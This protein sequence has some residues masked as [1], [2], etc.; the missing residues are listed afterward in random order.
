[1]PEPQPIDA[2]PVRLL[3]DGRDYPLGSSAFTL[4]R[5]PDCD[6]VFESKH[7]PTVSA[8][9]CEIVFDRQMYVLHD[10]SR[11]GTLVNE[12]PIMDEMP[13]QAGD[14]IRLG[15]GGPLLQFLGQPSETHRAMRSG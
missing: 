1:L 14:W 15:P 13:L 4:G 8:H 10:H 5:H 3:F 7:Y 6:I 9:H 11:N 2:G 12:R